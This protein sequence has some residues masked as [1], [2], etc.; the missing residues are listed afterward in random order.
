[1]HGLTMPWRRSILHPKVNNPTQSHLNS[2]L[3]KKKKIPH[4][5]QAYNKWI[6]REDHDTLRWSRVYRRPVA[7]QWADFKVKRSPDHMLS[8]PYI[9]WFFS[10]NKRRDMVH[11]HV[12]TRKITIL[13]RVVARQP[14]M[15]ARVRA[16]MGFRTTGSWAIY[17]WS[18]LGL[19]F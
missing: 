14:H 3:K 2:I 16:R 4:H 9:S 12:S 5:V 19:I 18:G 10:K 1:M 11:R 6:T 8:H 15:R 7:R 13:V 17:P